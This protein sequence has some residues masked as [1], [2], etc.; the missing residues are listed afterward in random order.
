[1]A[2][3][4]PNFWQYPY[5]LHKQRRSLQWTVFAR[6]WYLYDC[7]WQ[8]PFDAAIKIGGVLQGENLV[9]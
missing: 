4:I 2:N 9:I 7:K 5:Q 1:M 3:R 6:N 8:D